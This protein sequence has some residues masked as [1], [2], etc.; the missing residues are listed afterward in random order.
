MPAVVLMLLLAAV[1]VS[2]ADLLARAEASFQAAVAAR[3]D[4]PKARPHLRAAIQDLETLQEHGVRNARLSLQLGNARLLA[5][6][7]A[8]AILAYHE[9]LALSPGD[10]SLREALDQARSRIAYPAGGFAHPPVDDLPPWLPQPSPMTLLLAT[11]AVFAFGCVAL[12]RWRM[13][14]ARTWLLAGIVGLV[15]TMV[16]VVVIVLQ[17]RH[18]ASEGPLVV[19]A[20]E[21]V[22]LRRG[23]GLTYPPRYSTPLPRGTE[24]RLRRERGDWLQIQLAGGEIGWVPRS[25]TRQG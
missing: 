5:D 2:D 9:G 25:L 22:L 20:A 21:D 10:R 16:G 8:G 15:I 11:V 18:R 4:G 12:T 6:D 24:A 17:E 7:L 14:T 1:D 13:T 23:D 3:D 19:I